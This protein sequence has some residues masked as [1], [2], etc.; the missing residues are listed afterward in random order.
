MGAFVPL[1]Q[2]FVRP[3]RP[4][5]DEVPV[6]G[7]PPVDLDAEREAAWQAGHA[8]AER[9]AAVRIAALEEQLKAAV[10]LIAEVARARREAVE[11][12]AVDVAELVLGLAR[13]VAGDALTVHPD[14]LPGLVRGALAELPDEDEVTIRVAP[15]QVE[16]VRAVLPEPHRGRVVAAP[17]IDVGCVVET[18]H[19]AI[20]AT[21]GAAVDAIT[22]ATAAWLAGRA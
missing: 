16:R 18:R 10:P 2:H 6:A 17:D 21:L 20:D 22:A 5:P 4:V 9:A 12:A 14:A 13:K 11:Q 3:V 7:P 19:V 1:V 8:A 15:D